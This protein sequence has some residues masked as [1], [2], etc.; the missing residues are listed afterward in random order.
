MISFP[1][2]ISIV[3]QVRRRNRRTTRRG[4]WLRSHRRIQHRT[5]RYSLRLLAADRAAIS[6]DRLGSERGMSDRVNG[7]GSWLR[8]WR[9]NARSIAY[10]TELLL[11]CQCESQDERFHII[12]LPLWRWPL[13]LF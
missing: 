10:R 11:G 2:D 6:Q 4:R 13:E 3:V 7:F 8:R 12:S 1:I 5:G 9:S